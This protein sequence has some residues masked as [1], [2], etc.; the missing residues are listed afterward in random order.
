M[1]LKARFWLTVGATLAATALFSGTAR[2]QL[3]TIRI[4]EVM[5]KNASYPD[6][7]GTISDWVELYNTGSVAVN[8]AGAS[9]TD[10]NLYPARFVF[11]PNTFIQPNGYLLITCDSS[12]P[13]SA[14]NAEFGLTASG[15]YMYL[16]PPGATLGTTPVDSV[17]YG[18]Q[19]EDY[20]I[21][22]VP[23][24]TGSWTLCRPTFRSA[25]ASVATGSADTL[26]INEW[27]AN[28]DGGDDW[29]ELC[30]TNAQPV[31]IGG[32][33]LSDTTAVPFQYRIPNLSFIGDG[34]RLSFIK[35]IADGNT[36]A[37]NADHVNFSLKAGGE[38]VTL[39]KSDG[40]TPIQVV[41]FGSQDKGVSEGWLPD[42]NLNNRARFGPDVNGIS[43]ATP[44]KPNSLPYTGLVINELLA[45]TDPPLEDAIEFLN[46][47]ASPIDI[48][49]WWL[50]NQ[51]V[52]PKRALIPA[53]PPIP[54]GGFRVIYEYQF[55]TNASSYPASYPKTNIVRSFTFNSAHGDEA[56]LFQ[57]DANGNLTGYRVSE[58][59]ESSAN[60]VS[61]GRY[62][63]IGI[64]GD[65]KFV[66]Q[67][68]TTFGHDNPIT[69]ED[70]RLGT[71]MSNA[72]P[73]VGPVVINEVMYHPISGSP[74][75]ENPNEEYIELRNTTTEY[76][77]LFDPDYPTNHWRLQKS[78]E[79]CLSRQQLPAAEWLCAGGA[80]RPLHEWGHLGQFSSPLQ[81]AGWHAHLWPVGQ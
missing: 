74:P 50:S 61:F 78:G 16:Y 25:N 58:V 2:A 39:Y 37:Y 72:Y 7:D 29:F 40:F 24:G 52:D 5:A 44:G 54:P 12:R 62:N 59:F 73:K 30:N 34:F 60:G 28:P 33:Y 26:K 11:K 81:R 75:L 14:T 35:F 15:G 13:D 43:T 70:F 45:H 23:D 57:T 8:L 46:V 41:T 27:M 32:L 49:G 6:V 36:N 55:D 3:N 18:I 17:L 79:L 22:R 76:V 65:Y 21:G 19:T 64:P 31:A 66:A 47:S 1:Q 9:L 67:S 42:A 69:V 56:H 68:R 80:L 63:T 71:G 51:R 10:S 20:T 48:S 53:G 77:P 38:Q 4:N